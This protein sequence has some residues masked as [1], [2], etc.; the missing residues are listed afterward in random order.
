MARAKALLAAPRFEIATNTPPLLQSTGRLDLSTVIPAVDSA[1][2]RPAIEDVLKAQGISKLSTCVLESPFIGCKPFSAPRFAK[3]W[4]EMERAVE[5]GLCDR[6]GV[7]HM[8]VHKLRELGGI[9]SEGHSIHVE[10]HPL[11]MQRPLAHFCKSRGI[12]LVALEPLAPI[13]T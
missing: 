12:S 13:N 1:S 5:T 7:Q 6:I 11:L 4:G 10:L 2:L 9:I 8:T 3:A